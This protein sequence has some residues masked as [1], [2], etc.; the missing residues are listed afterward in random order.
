MSD[1]T[2][3]QELMDIFYEEAQAN[4]EEMRKG[5]SI[6]GEEYVPTILHRLILCAHNLKSSSGIV[7]FHDLS[8]LS[9]ALEK[10]FKKAK[11][12]KIEL[13]ADVVS[14]LSHSIEVCQKLLNKEK[15]VD[16][17]ELLSQLNKFTHL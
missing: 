12:E 15:G 3:N 13:N 7:G 2:D 4:I 1:M 10:I 16:Y 9:S 14:I 17:K 6:L 5:L 11:V 8:K